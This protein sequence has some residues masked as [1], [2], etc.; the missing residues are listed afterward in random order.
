MLQHLICFPVWPGTS[1]VATPSAKRHIGHVPEMHE[2]SCDRGAV[3]Q[4]PNSGEAVFSPWWSRGAAA[5]QT[6]REEGE[7]SEL[8]IKSFFHHKS[9]EKCEALSHS[10]FSWHS[11]AACN[12]LD[13]LMQLTFIKFITDGWIK[14]R[15][16]SNLDS[17]TGPVLCCVPFAFII[18]WNMSVSWLQVYDY[19]L[20]DMYLNN[21]LALPVNSSPVMVF[22]QQNFRAQIDPLRYTMLHNRSIN[23]LVISFNS[24]GGHRFMTNRHEATIRQNK[25]LS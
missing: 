9:T 3:C 15:Q 21:R 20:N 22:P 25:Y 6:R 13:L 17:L 2:A 24:G 19:W 7:V 1:Q 18:V 12:P 4:D 23:P 14:G 10:S 8:G 16:K 5:K 11:M